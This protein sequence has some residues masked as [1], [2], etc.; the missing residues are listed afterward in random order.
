MSGSQAKVLAAILKENSTIENIGLFNNRIGD[1]GVAA[2]AKAL[3]VNSTLQSLELITNQ[4]CAD[5]AKAMAEALKKT[6]L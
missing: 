5:G 4:I 6:P 1:E 2:L 3:R